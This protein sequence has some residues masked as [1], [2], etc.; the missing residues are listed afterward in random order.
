[1]RYNDDRWSMSD[2]SVSERFAR[3]F[4][5]SDDPGLCAINNITPGCV[6]F[7]VIFI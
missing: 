1:M 2:E 7:R 4:C 5:S 6:G 3:L